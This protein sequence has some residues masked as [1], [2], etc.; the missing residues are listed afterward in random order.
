MPFSVTL[1]QALDAGMNGVEHLYYILKG[2]SKDELEITKQFQRG[3][4]GFGKPCPC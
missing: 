3:A 1:N 2:S 4:L